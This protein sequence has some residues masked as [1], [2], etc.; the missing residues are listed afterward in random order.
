MY[1]GQYKYAINAMGGA[2][3]APDEHV[4]LLCEI[5]WNGFF[6]GWKPEK[7]PLWKAA[8]DKYGMLY[9]SIHAP[10]TGVAA[11]WQ[12]GEMAEKETNMYLACLEDCAK[13]QISVMVLHPFIG[14]E[15]HTPTEVGI[16]NFAKVVKRADALGV[17][18]GFENVEG[19]EYLAAIFEAFAGH[20]SLGFCFDTGHEL[21]YNRGK[22]MLALYGHKLCHTHFNDNVG[23]TGADIFWTDDLHLVMGDGIADWEDIMHRIRACDYQDVLTCELTLANKPGKNTHDGYAAM[24]IKD[25]YA[26]ALDR[27]KKIGAMGR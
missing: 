9:T 11:M 3:L 6:T 15:D 21:C 17:R 22:D 13:H 26:L 8:A 20:P 18:L 12:G 24:P 16:Q 1:T 2:H 23:V 27:M 25:F 4:R 10:F 7:T 5:G 14:F 19:E